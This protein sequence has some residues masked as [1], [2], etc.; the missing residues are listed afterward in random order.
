MVR[1]HTFLAWI[2]CLLLVA[3]SS[4]PVRRISEPAAS[5]QQLSVDA[6]G[7]WSVDLR[8]QNY[9]SIAMRFDTLRLELTAGDTAAGTLEAA[10]QLSIAGAS[11]DVVTLQLTPTAEAR[12][13][14]ADALAGGRTL[15]YALRGELGAA[16]ADRG[17]ARDYR[18]D[19][20][21]VLS[22]VPGLPGVLR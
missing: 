1:S 16:P 6:D 13:L 21:G 5:I 20:N 19:R 7:G 9:S 3:C 18:I 2:A 15:P 22:P 10:P 11:A 12:I 4:G 8:V 14:L 17:R